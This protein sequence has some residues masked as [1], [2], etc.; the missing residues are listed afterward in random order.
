MCSGEGRRLGKVVVPEEVFDGE[1]FWC[2]RAIGPHCHVVGCEEGR[3]SRRKV[4][5]AAGLM[6]V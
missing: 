1:S 5:A 4:Y 6:A 3:K 2:G